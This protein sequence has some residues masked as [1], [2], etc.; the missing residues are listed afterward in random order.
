[1]PTITRTT[2]GMIDPATGTV[3]A[4]INS[5]RASFTAGNEITASHINTLLAI[6]RSFNDHYHSTDDYAFEAYGNTYPVGSYYAASPRYTS[7][8]GG[9]EPADVTAGDTITSA[10]HEEIRGAIT[11]ANGHYHSVEDVVY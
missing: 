7:R 2:S 4:S 10:K 6:W 8:M 5:L 3:Q 9:T 11:Q 1:M